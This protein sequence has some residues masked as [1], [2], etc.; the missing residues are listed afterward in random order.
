MVG[1]L[2]VGAIF[3]LPM[4]MNSLNASAAQR[5]QTTQVNSVISGIMKLFGGNSTS[6]NMSLFNSYLANPE[7]MPTSPAPS[8]W[9]SPIG[10]GLSGSP[11]DVP[12]PGLFSSPIGP[13]LGFNGDTV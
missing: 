5:N 3:V 4:L 11:V 9:S 8:M 7:S 13:G 10:P 12:S 6:S 2:G 1:L